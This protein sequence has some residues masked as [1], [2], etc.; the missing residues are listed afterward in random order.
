M[1]TNISNLV[2]REWEELDFRHM[3][4]NCFYEGNFGHDV[5]LFLSFKLGQ[6]LADTTV[7]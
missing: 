7:L 5:Y 2:S 3:K 6:N 4:L 1:Y